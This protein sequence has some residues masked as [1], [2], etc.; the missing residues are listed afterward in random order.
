MNK[1]L[2]KEEFSAKLLQVQ[3]ERKYKRIKENRRREWEFRDYKIN[4]LN[5]RKVYD[6]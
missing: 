6:I 4:C 5:P 3:R 2:T 1:V